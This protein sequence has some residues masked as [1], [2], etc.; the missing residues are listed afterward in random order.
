M[1]EILITLFVLSVGLL[2]VASMQFVGSFNNKNALARTQ[3]VFVAQQMAER[4]RASMEASEV[5]D[6]FVVDNQYFVDANYNFSR[7]NC[8]DSSDPFSC[9]CLVRP[10]TIP[11]CVD[12]AC[13]ASEF[14]VFDAYEMSCAAVATNPAAEI[15]V[16]CVDN[17]IADADACTAGSIHQIMVRWPALSWQNQ[18]TTLN[19]ACNENQSSQFDCVI[20]EILL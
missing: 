15:S 9:H 16:S 13:S 12:G 3:G 17:V 8:S 14:A 1:I 20:L 11:N 18:A 6:G 4:L 19:S 2:G 5:T 7:L 10:A